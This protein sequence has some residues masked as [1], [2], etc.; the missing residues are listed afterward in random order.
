MSGGGFTSLFRGLSLVRCAS[1]Y[2]LTVFFY[3]NMIDIHYLNK[4]IYLYY[5]LLGG[6]CVRVSGLCD[7]L[8]SMVNTQKTLK[9]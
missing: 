6:V 7:V 3:T 1:S 5:I 9:L 4:Y 2:G 8:L